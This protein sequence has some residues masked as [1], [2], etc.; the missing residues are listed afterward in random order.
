MNTPRSR[1]RARSSSI[2]LSPACTTSAS[3]LARL[4]G[5]LREAVE[6]LGR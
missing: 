3:D 2:Y 4:T 5:E 6:L 1:K